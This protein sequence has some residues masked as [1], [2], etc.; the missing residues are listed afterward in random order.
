MISLIMTTYN[1]E[2]YLEEQLDSIRNQSRTPD[3]VLIFDDRSK[4]ST[5]EL[6][7]SY[8]QKYKLTSWHFFE[9]EVNKGYALN[10]S[11]GMNQCNGDIIFL[12][13][14]DDI[15]L[16]EKIKEMSEIMETHPEISLLC[17]DVEPFYTGESPQKVNFEKFRSN[18][19]LIQISHIDKWI[20]PV[21]PGCSMCFK[22]SLLEEYNQIWYNG[23]PH[24]CLLWGLAVLDKMA[25]Y[26]NKVTIRFRRHDTN[27]SS[28]GGFKKEHRIQTINKEIGFIQ[29]MTEH[30]QDSDKKTIK[31]M[32][33][34]QLALYEKRVKILKKRNVFKA[35]FLFP[36]MKYYGRKRFWLTDVYYCMKS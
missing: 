9:N 30:I 15:W 33:D 35:F 16:P 22:K 25:Y 27:A 8:I 31:R 1:G 11:D 29:K 18:N 2:K 14:Q 32:L 26:Y 19:P 3:E 34:K 6:V 5:A 23:Y 36:Y 13:D 7:R 12:A 21:R 10:F 20:K 28:R 24:D 17:S 4:D